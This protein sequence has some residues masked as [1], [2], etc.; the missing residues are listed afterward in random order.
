M[1]QVR[2][3][4]IK[5]RRGEPLKVLL[6]GGTGLT[7]RQVRQ[8]L[9]EEKIEVAHTWPQNTSR[10]GVIPKDVGL[11]LLMKDSAGHGLLNHAVN[12]AKRQ[13]IPFIRTA[14]R[15]SL[16]RA[17]L[18]RRGALDLA[19]EAW[20]TKAKL[21]DNLRKEAEKVVE[22]ALEV[23]TKAPIKSETLSLSH[24]VGEFGKVLSLSSAIQKLLSE[25]GIEGVMID[26]NEVII[27]RTM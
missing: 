26:R 9:R 7:T 15:W 10:P 12:Q 1:G 2:Q 16:M 25:A 20:S 24:G 8:K 4:P 21:D 5:L 3:P 11:V 6:V 23:P 27:T 22:K 17:A 13:G 19:M 14:R 18:R